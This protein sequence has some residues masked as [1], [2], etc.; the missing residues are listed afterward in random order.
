[1]RRNSNSSSC[2][3]FGTI[4]AIVIFILFLINRQRLVLWNN[5]LCNIPLDTK[6]TNQSMHVW[7]P[8]IDNRGWLETL[9]SIV[10]P[11]FHFKTQRVDRY[12]FKRP[13]FLYCPDHSFNSLILEFYGACLF[14]FFICCNNKSNLLS[15]RPCSINICIR[16]Y[17]SCW[18]ILSPLCF[19]SGSFKVILQKCL[20]LIF[21]CD[22]ITYNV[23]LYMN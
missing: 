23:N 12:V 14:S 10:Q 22:I 7:I 6:Q 17:W 20:I 11:A 5:F 13:D 15:L 3:T 19:H 21:V 4:S 2:A 1:M 9:W 18:I 16:E 8:L